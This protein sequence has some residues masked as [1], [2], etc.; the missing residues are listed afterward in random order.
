MVCLQSCQEVIVA[1]EGVGQEVGQGSG[2]LD[3]VG[4][5]RPWHCGDFCLGCRK[6][7]FAGEILRMRARVCV[8]V[9]GE[10]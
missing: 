8:C 5:H 7:A 1:G 10:G 6:K 4:P 9:C 2:G 3:C